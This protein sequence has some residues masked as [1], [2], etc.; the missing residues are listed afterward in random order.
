MDWNSC[1]GCIECLSDA[2]R[3]FTES[4]REL[5]LRLGEG[6]CGDIQARFLIK[7]L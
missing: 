7:K 6:D 1:H 3:V 5:E 2:S 4:M